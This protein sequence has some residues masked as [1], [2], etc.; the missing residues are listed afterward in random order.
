MSHSPGP[1][2]WV[3]HGWSGLSSPTGPVI[4]PGDCWCE[5]CRKDKGDNCQH[6]CVDVEVPNRDD[7]NLIAAAPLMLSTLREC[8]ARFAHAGMSTYEIDEVLA[9]IDGEGGG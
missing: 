4:R 2:R 7:L 1:W 5:D 9:R 6:V 3:N 8:R